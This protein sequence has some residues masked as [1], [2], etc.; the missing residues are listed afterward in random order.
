MR[1]IVLIVIVIV[2]AEIIWPV[3]SLNKCVTVSWQQ[4]EFLH[5]RVSRELEEDVVSLD[6]AAGIHGFQLEDARA[7][8]PRSPRGHETGSLQPTPVARFKHQLDLSPETWVKQ[9]RPP[10]LAR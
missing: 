6:Q 7:E 4:D 3:M 8:F 1:C 9:G 2:V 5:L 10:C